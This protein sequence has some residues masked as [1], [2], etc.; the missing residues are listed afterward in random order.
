MAGLEGLHGDGRVKS[1]NYGTNRVLGK[2][3]CAVARG[4]N[5]AN[6]RLGGLLLRNARAGAIWRGKWSE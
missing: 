4:G 1:K 5:E 6:G 2:G 3:A